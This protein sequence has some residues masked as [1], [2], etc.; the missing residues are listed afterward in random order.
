VGLQK[1]ITRASEQK[2]LQRVVQHDL[3][4]TSTKFGVIP[5][6]SESLRSKDS[7]MGRDFCRSECVPHVG[8]FADRSE[9]LASNRTKPPMTHVTTQNSSKGL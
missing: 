7:K 9:E 3:P 1:L 5:R 8:H 4:L 6:R 2:I